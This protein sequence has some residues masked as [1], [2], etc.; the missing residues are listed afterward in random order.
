MQLSPRG[1]NPDPPATPTVERGKA[2]EAS[3]ASFHCKMERI[4]IVPH[5]NK[6]HCVD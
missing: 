1:A 4:I 6:G 5:P 3:I 2:L